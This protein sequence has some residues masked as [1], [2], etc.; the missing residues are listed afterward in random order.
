MDLN[1]TV[2]H[3]SERVCDALHEL[4]RLDDDG[5]RRRR[6]SSQAHRSCVSVWLVRRESEIW[7]TRLATPYCKLSRASRPVLS[8]WKGA[9][10]EEVEEVRREKARERHGHWAWEEAAAQWAMEQ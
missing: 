6:V 2:S 3:G 9:P 10:M 8:G 7:M 1:L 4:W 5:H